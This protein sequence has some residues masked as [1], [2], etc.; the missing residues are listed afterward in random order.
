MKE[1]V[2]NYFQFLY[3][4][5]WKKQ[6]DTW[7]ISEGIYKLLSHNFNFHLI[8]PILDDKYFSFCKDNIIKNLDELNPWT[9]YSVN[10][11]TKNPFHISNEDSEILANKWFNLLKDIF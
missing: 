5:E 11:E 7:I 1:N 3:D 10:K 2:N 4:M 8:T 9:Y 6:Q